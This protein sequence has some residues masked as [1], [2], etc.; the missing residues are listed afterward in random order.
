MQIGKEK[1]KISLFANDIIV[2]L[3]DPKYSTRELLQL[4]NNLAT[5]LDIKLTQTNQYPL[6]TQKIN[7]LRKKLGKQYPSQ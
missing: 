3:S 7:G 6:N 2:Y 4:I 1:V 5:W